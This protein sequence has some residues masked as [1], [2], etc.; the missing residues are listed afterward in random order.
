MRHYSFDK[1]FLGIVVGLVFFGGLI[2]LSAALG[3]LARGSVQ[4][5]SL[6]FNQLGLGIVFGGAALWLCQSIPYRFWKRYSFYIFLATFFMSL[7]VFIP[8]LGIEHGGATRWIALGSFSFQPA[9]LLKFGFVVYLAAW[10]SLLQRKLTDWRHAILPL[11]ALLAL[12]GGV[13]LAEPDTGTFAV[14]MASGIG[15]LFAGGGK[16]RHIAGIILC[17]LIGLF[18]LALWKPYVQDRILTFLDPSRDPTGAAYQIQQ[19]LITIGSGGLSGRGF[20]Q[21]IQKFGYLPEPVGDSIFAVAAE[22]FGFIGSVLLIILFLAFA[23]RGLHIAKKSPDTFSGLLVVGLVI[24]IGSQSFI[25]MAAM[26]GLVPLTGMPLLFV[27]HGGTA[28]FV[29][30]AEVGIILNISKYQS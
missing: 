24:L 3:L 10:L 23:L 5:S 25:N 28:M 9:E 29:A 12:T 16:L 21:S 26:V 15:M 1:I 13:L 2:F 14:I 7:S 18:L 20:G 22:E 17:A 8:G 30:L 4:I 6:I 11:I 27:S 19:S